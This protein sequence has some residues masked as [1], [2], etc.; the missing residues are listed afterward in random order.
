MASSGRFEEATSVTSVA[1]LP[2]TQTLP[3]M[4]AEPAPP[5][6]ESVAPD[7]WQFASSGR[8]EE[9]NSAAA[10]KPEPSLSMKAEPAP[11]AAGS[12]AP[13]VR[14]FASSG[15]FDD[16]TSVS[17]AAAPKTEPLPLM[18][19]ESAPPA[20]ESSFSKRPGDAKMRNFASSGRF[21]D[22][23]TVS[24]SRENTVNTTSEETGEVVVDAFDEEAAMEA[25]NTTNGTD[26]SLD[27]SASPAVAVHKYMFTYNGA[28]AGADIW[29]RYGMISSLLK[30]QSS[31]GHLMELRG[32]TS[33]GADGQP[34]FKHLVV[35][36]AGKSIVEAFANNASETKKGCNLRG[37]TIKVDGK[38]VPSPSSGEALNLTTASGL[39]L[40]VLTG[41]EKDAALEMEVKRL[42]KE[43]EEKAAV[44]K[45]V[46]N[47]F[48]KETAFEAVNVSNGT[49]LSPPKDIMH[50][51]VD[52]YD[53]LTAKFS[54]RTLLF[55]RHGDQAQDT[56]LEGADGARAEDEDLP[57]ISLEQLEIDTGADLHLKTIQIVSS[58]ASKVDERNERAQNRV[59]HNHLTVSFPAGLP[60]GCSGMLAEVAG[61][62]PLSLETKAALEPRN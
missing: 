45:F 14:Q 21:D 10:P 41:A 27:A 59:P 11:P 50:I 48:D 37:M 44:G 4:K 55:T 7:M 13:D 57:E 39:Y 35:A 2:K 16:S 29:L 20:A 47:M 56:G 53:E 17:A 30:W 54:N 51:V 26:L 22:S 24:S 49:F 5:A 25:V 58:I 28:G 62:S 33:A 42:Q 31:D 3:S 15:R 1:A 6:A 8:F 9:A 61:L 38:Q 19:A 60:D 40:S 46:V 34:T 36:R 23:S 52:A 12:V 43:L 18:K 32:V